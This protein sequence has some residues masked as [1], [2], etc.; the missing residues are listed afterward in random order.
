MEE[1]LITE[2]EAEGD[3]SDD[4]SAPND[5]G[6]LATGTTRLQAT[7]QGEPRDLDYVSVT[8]PDGA[9]LTGFGLDDYQ[10]GDGNLAFLGLQ[11][12]AEFTVDPDAPETELLL[13]G[14]LYGASRI[15]DDLLGDIG[16]LPD[17]IGFEGPLPAGTYTLWLNQTGPASTATLS[18]TVEP[19]DTDPGVFAFSG[20]PFRGEDV[21]APDRQIVVG[22]D[23]IEDFDFATDRYLI[24][25]VDFGLP[26]EVRF[27]TVDTTDPDAAIP[28]DANVVVV[29]NAD[30]DADAETPFLAGTA[31]GEIAALT[32][33][34]RPGLFV[35]FNS[36]LDLNRV[37]YSADLASAE[38]DLSV[39]SRQTDLTGTDAVDA[40]AAFSAENFEF[41]EV[42]EPGGD[43][44]V[45]TDGDD[46]LSVED[47]AAVDIVDGGAGA[48]SVTLPV[49]LDEARFAPTDGGFQLEAA[50]ETVDLLGVERFELTDATLVVDVGETAATVVRLFQTVFDRGPEIGGASFW[51]GRAED[52]PRG[53]ALVADAFAV[54][55]ELE[56]RI[57]PDASDE[58]FVASLYTS[59]LDREGE[60][61]GIAFWSNALGTGALSRG[62]V[63]LA[64]A[65]SPEA[66]ALYENDV[67]DGVLLLV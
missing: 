32:D 17:A 7:Q 33:A 64:F 51:T 12:G 63:I 21:S 26:E 28:E 1:T 67:D 39:L 30:N 24:D 55:P 20:D 16:T 27:A 46:A 50:G 66:V 65:E 53:V 45:G 47:L 58:D 38:A 3:F 59:G 37:V 41:G 5:L 52:D 13:G 54:A 6:T 34:S 22:E 62:D 44:L 10:A 8:V 23:A 9:Q 57:G 35:Y 18:L 48:D 40:L 43:A 36:T 61:G 56:A 4:R 11:A 15:G 19:L 49:T 42:V 25:A 60:A 31:A 14:V 29:L 2:T